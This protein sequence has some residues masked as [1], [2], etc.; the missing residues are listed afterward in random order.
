L[1]FPSLAAIPF[2][3]LS[4]VLSL[5]G[6]VT[7]D[8]TMG[9]K[10]NGGE[11]ATYTL[12]A[13]SEVTAN[14]DDP[15]KSENQKSY[16]ALVGQDDAV[17]TYQRAKNIVLFDFS[18]LGSFNKVAN[19]VDKA[20]SG[21]PKLPDVYISTE[22][23]TF[24]PSLSPGPRDKTNLAGAAIVQSTT[25]TK[26]S[27]QAYGR[28]VIY[29]GAVNPQLIPVIGAAGYKDKGVSGRGAGAAFDPFGLP[30]SGSPFPYQVTLDASLKLDDRSDA[31]GLVFFAVDSRDVDPNKF[32][33]DGEPF[34]KAVWYLH[35]SANG[36]LQ[37]LSDL[38]DPAKLQIDFH[39]NDTSILKAVLAN[40]QPISD[41]AI[42]DAIRRSFTLGADDTATLSSYPLFPY[43]MNPNE[44]PQPGLAGMTLYSVNQDGVTYGQG[45]NAGI[46]SVP[47]PSSLAL[48]SLGL[49]TLTCWKTRKRQDS[50]Q[51]RARP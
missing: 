4:P 39:I 49:L 26:D 32:Y 2:I 10:A 43:Q 11:L 42:D 34:D 7:G 37:S 24:S 41:Q 19:F 3:L 9:F 18:S 5:A 35:I 23:D 44:P 22:N 48:L 1:G 17:R 50:G 30:L 47:E 28:A 14:P 13:Y 29:S 46:S 33:A 45:V 16:E 12:F 51:A 6:Y 40:G 38:E 20:K 25:Y 21:N 8:T 27:K 15:K 36:P 31:G